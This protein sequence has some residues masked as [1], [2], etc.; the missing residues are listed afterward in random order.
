[1]GNKASTILGILDLY[2]GHPRFCAPHVTSLFQFVED[3][4]GFIHP[5]SML[6]SEDERS[7]K[8]ISLKPSGRQP[9]TSKKVSPKDKQQPI[10]KDDK[11]LKLFPD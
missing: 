4:H 1:V 9:V 3:E 11:Q 7:L 2:Q 6:M 5:A 8:P 10:H